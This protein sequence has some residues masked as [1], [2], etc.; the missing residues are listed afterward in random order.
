[1]SINASFWT[2]ALLCLSGPSAGFLLKFS[3]DSNLCSFPQF[4]GRQGGDR[5][6]LY[7]GIPLH[8][9]LLNKSLAQESKNCKI[10]NLLSKFIQR[11]N[12]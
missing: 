11:N 2:N 8:P 3:M 9:N 7:Y 1:M 12:V 4:E 5:L 6:G 10:S